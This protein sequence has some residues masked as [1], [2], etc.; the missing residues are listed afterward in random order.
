MDVMLKPNRNARASDSKDFR[1]M[2][3]PG[4]MTLGVFFPVEALRHPLH[5][6]KAAARVD[7]LTG[8][9]LVLGVASGD[10]P[11]EFPAFGA[12]NVDLTEHPDHPPQP[13][14]PGFR[15]GRDVVLRFLEG[16]RS[17]D[18]HHAPS[19][20]STRGAARPSCSTR[21]GRFSRSS[22][23]ARAP[24]PLTRHELF[25]TSSMRSSEKR[26]KRAVL[27]SPPIHHVRLGHP[28]CSEP[29]R[30][31]SRASTMRRSYPAHGQPRC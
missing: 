1:R 2:F 14:P 12:L 25:L 21:S 11:A 9:R 22:R 17:A 30:A 23:A 13:I 15:G 19:I 31:S 24:P 16:L 27:G 5:T 10:R 28:M 29:S 20:S 7:Q 3:A 4:R 8:G 18:V 6:A 26:A